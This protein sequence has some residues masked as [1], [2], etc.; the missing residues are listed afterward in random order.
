[1][2]HS[3]RRPF[4]HGA[5][6]NDGNDPL[7]AQITKSRWFPHRSPQNGEPWSGM[8]ELVTKLAPNWDLSGTKLARFIKLHLLTWSEPQ[9]GYRYSL[10]K[11]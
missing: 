7:Q 6:Q 11:T 3:R 2:A 1:M 5:A 10:R 9:P 8:A 4:H